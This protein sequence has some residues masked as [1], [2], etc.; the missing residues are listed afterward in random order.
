MKIRMKCG[1]WMDEDDKKVVQYIEDCETWPDV[2]EVAAATG[3]PEHRV[4]LSLRA[5]RVQMNMAK[6]HFEFFEEEKCA[7]PKNQSKESDGA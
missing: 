2:S 5:I 1:T 3:L 4:R 7:E 6:P